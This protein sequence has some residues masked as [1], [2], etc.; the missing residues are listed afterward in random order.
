MKLCWHL[1]SGQH[2]AAR[3]AYILLRF[4]TPAFIMLKFCCAEEKTRAAGPDM[5]TPTGV[6]GGHNSCKVMLESWAIT[7][8]CRML[9]S[10]AALMAACSCCSAC[11][12]SS[13]GSRCTAG[14]PRCAVSIFSEMTGSL[15]L[16]EGEAL[17]GEDLGAVSGP[18]ADMLL[19]DDDTPCWEP[20]C[21]PVSADCVPGFCRLVPG[22]AAEG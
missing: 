7:G 22:A 16:D 3:P 9:S 8:I 6:L 15:P 18:S 1:Q 12:A 2:P 4:A 17:R 13:W 14:V 10:Y 5:C 20:G 19:C 11:S 21:A